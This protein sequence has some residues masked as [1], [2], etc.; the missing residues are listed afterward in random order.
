MRGYDAINQASEHVLLPRL[1]SERQVGRASFA[2]L[3][4]ADQAWV[5]GLMGPAQRGFFFG[6]RVPAEHLQSTGSGPRLSAAGDPSKEP[7]ND[8]FGLIGDKENYRQSRFPEVYLFCSYV[9]P[10]WW[11]GAVLSLLCCVTPVLAV[12]LSALGLTA[13]V[14]KLD[15]VLVPVFVASI[16][17]V[18]FA[19]VRRRR[20][21][22]AKTP[23]PT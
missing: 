22:A 2:Q 8:G 17:L 5:L 16:A 4:F 23:E 20:S 15:Y 9:L 11:P 7:L 6:I 13:F 3:G 10:A 1:Q 21:C 18:I 12:L 19:L 14:A